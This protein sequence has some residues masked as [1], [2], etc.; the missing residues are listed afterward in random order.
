MSRKRRRSSTEQRL[1][2]AQE[3]DQTLRK[4]RATSLEERACRLRKLRNWTGQASFKAAILSVVLLAAADPSVWLWT[5]IPGVGSL[6]VYLLQ[7]LYL[8]K[9]ERERDFYGWIPDTRVI[10]PDWKQM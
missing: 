3:A 7:G 6:A 9:L 4:E 2:Q 10:P 1:L 8:R 5:L